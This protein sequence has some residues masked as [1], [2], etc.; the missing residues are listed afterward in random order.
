LSRYYSKDGTLELGYHLRKEGLCKILFMEASIV[1][2]FLQNIS[3]LV[4]TPY[5]AKFILIL[6]LL[7]GFKEFFD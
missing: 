1:M 6:E 2:N 3:K 4:I 5:S 7:E